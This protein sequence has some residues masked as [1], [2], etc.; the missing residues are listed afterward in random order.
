[1][2]HGLAIPGSDALLLS[3]ATS[4]LKLL[5]GFLISNTRPALGSESGSS[6]ERS[7]QGE[8]APGA[9]LNHP[10]RFL[11]DRTRQLQRECSTFQRAIPSF[12]FALSPWF[13][14]DD[15]VKSPG[16]ARLKSEASGPGMAR[17]IHRDVRF[18]RDR[19]RQPGRPHP[20]NSPVYDRSLRP[21]T[22][23]L[24]THNEARI[25]SAPAIKLGQ[26]GFSCQ[27]ARFTSSPAG[28]CM[29]FIMPSVPA[30]TWVA[31]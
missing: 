31:P 14:C 18:L 21:T 20:C 5:H 11:R 15:A 1:M 6:V 17:P 10:V 30:S 7:S 13:C 29:L 22:Q 4:S 24:C 23:R 25:T 19:T 8:K 3:C 9:F 28:T 26:C 27:I 16:L 2:Q 12:I